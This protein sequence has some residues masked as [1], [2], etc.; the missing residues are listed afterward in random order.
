MVEMPFSDVG[1]VAGLLVIAGFIVVG[2]STV[3]FG[4]VFVMLGRFAMMV[5]GLR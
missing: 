3:M 2:C 5:C 4:R 1:M